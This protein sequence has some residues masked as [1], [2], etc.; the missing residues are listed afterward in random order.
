M[1]V[2]STAQRRSD[3]DLSQQ[4][5]S[6]VRVGDDEVMRTTRLEAFS[7]GVF[8]IAVTLLV[9]DLRV[10][11]RG[12]LTHGLGAALRAEWPTYAAYF[13]SFWVIGIIWINHHTVLDAIGRIDKTL[14]VLNLALLLTVVTIPFTT[15]LFAAYLQAGRSAHLAAALYSGL[16]LIHAV[17]WSAFWRHAAYRPQL[18][19]PGVDPVE[20]K[21]S[22]P[23]F[24]LGTPIYAVTVGLSFVNAYVV[25]IL[26]LV[27]ALAYLRG[28]INL[29]ESVAP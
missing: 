19:A 3:R 20:A 2:E 10:P 13:V 16:M 15:S 9:L 24:A 27:L 25:L 1:A 11:N 6:D 28:M 23:R 26:H 29:G 21:A 8:A 17:L 4:T 14:L 5:L 7:D 18:L 22:V 12:T